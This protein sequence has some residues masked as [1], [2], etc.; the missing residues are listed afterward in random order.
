MKFY[1]FGDDHMDLPSK[2]ELEEKGFKVVYFD[3]GVKY[4][5][6]AYIRIDTLEELLRLVEK[7]GK[8]IVDKNSERDIKTDYEIE[9]YDNW[10]E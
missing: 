8:V 1:I 7:V 6:Q 3:K 5:E 2:Y 10:R 9:I 4:R